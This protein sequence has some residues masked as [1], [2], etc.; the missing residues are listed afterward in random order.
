MSPQSCSG[1]SPT[2]QR[3][4]CPPATG[5]HC[6]S[7][8]IR[9]THGCLIEPAGTNLLLQQRK[10]TPENWSLPTVHPVVTA[11]DAGELRGSAAALQARATGHQAPAPPAH[12][13]PLTA[14]AA[15]EG[16]CSEAHFIVRE[17]RPGARCSGVSLDSLSDLEKVAE[18]QSF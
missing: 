8:H 18:S 12:P 7:S 11:P 10:L 3:V 9:L 6:S 1:P 2:L 17:L 14:I 4:A 15:R 13:V 16:R 5:P